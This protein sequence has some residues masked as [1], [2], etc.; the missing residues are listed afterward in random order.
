[1]PVAPSGL[2]QAPGY[3]VTPVEAGEVTVGEVMVGEVAAGEVA[4]GEVTVGDVAVGDVS[5]VPISG[6]SGHG[7][8]TKPTHDA[9]SRFLIRP[10]SL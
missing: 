10:H 7:A 6:A 5:I 1:M 9:P 3:T 2:H 8:I 4:A